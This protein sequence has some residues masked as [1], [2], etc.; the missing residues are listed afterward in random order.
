[1][2]IAEPMKGMAKVSWSRKISAAWRTELD[3]GQLCPLG[4]GKATLMAVGADAPTKILEFSVNCYFFIFSVHLIQIIH[5]PSQ[6]NSSY[7]LSILL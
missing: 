7:T 4:S 3:L 2:L 5:I 1:M 6:L